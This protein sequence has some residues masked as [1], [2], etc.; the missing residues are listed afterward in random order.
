MPALV[1]LDQAK[2]ACRENPTDPSNDDELS[3]LISVATG[4][5]RSI[6]GGPLFTETITDEYVRCDDDRTLLLTKRPIV[7]VATIKSEWSGAVLSWPDLTIDKEHGIIRR[8]FGWRLY[9]W[10]D[11]YLVTYSAGWGA[12]AT[13]NPEAFANFTEAALAIVANLWEVRRGP[14]PSVGTWI[15][16][17]GPGLAIPIRARELMAPYAREVYV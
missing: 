14:V 9:G 5:L 3:R 1:T 16:E 6:T 17:G 4:N 13:D 7:A 2:R 10:T 8:R 15:P 12:A 11:T